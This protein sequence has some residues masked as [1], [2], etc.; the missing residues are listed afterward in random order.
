MGPYIPISKNT[1]YYGT[2]QIASKE[3]GL[4]DVGQFS[5]LADKIE[6]TNKIDKIL[7]VI[8]NSELR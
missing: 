6:L 3:Y 7:F 5:I 4:G 1:E 2:R 8:Y